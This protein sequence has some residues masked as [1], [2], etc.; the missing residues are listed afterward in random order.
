MLC[1]SCFLEFV[2][3]HYVQLCPKSKLA[4]GLTSK[5][6]LRL[7]RKRVEPI[8]GADINCTRALRPHSRAVVTSVTSIR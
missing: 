8:A 5:D 7:C 4:D 1:S 3:T 2:G 6:L